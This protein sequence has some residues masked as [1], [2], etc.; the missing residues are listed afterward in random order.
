MIFA[1]LPSSECARLTNRIPHMEATGLIAG[2]HI[3]VRDARFAADVARD[4]RAL[5]ALRR[6]TNLPIEVHLDVE[7]PLSLM[8]AY[9]DAGV[10]RIIVPAETCR[11][12][13]TE[14]L[15]ARALRVQ[16]G[17]ALDPGTP[18]FRL[19][20][21]VQDIDQVLLLG[22]DPAKTAS[23]R[24]MIDFALSRAMLTLE[25]GVRIE[26]AA[27]LLLSGA[28][29]LVIGSAIFAKDEVAA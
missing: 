26:N 5:A 20:H 16:I 25:S 4:A 14:I 6:S 7:G 9:A 12:L 21:L 3:D 11:L 18:A 10:S 19:D 24:R 17:V 29:S 28:H 1:S 22:A 23:C 13:H 2:L 27:R 15:V 8:K